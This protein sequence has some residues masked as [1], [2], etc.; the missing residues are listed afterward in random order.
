VEYDEVDEDA[1]GREQPFEE[2]SVPR[3]LALVALEAAALARR[4]F[5]AQEGR[6]RL[7]PGARQVILALALVDQGVGLMRSQLSHA[8]ALDRE[9]ALEALAEL[10]A[11]GM[12]EL[13]EPWPIEEEESV[14]EDEPYS[15]TAA[16]VAEARKLAVTARRSLPAGRRAS[17]ARPSPRRAPP[18]RRPRAS[19]R[20]RG[21]RASARR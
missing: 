2:D 15:L 19:G 20:R 3:E 17:R 7:S 1:I 8:L 18:P 6:G 4:I 16:G 9:Q 5:P 11:F 21:R 12:V 13:A 14:E 10:L